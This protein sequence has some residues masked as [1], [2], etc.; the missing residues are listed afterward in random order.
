MAEDLVDVE[1]G[2]PSPA[3]VGA[4]EAWPGE[5]QTAGFG[6]FGSEKKALWQVWPS[7]NTF[8]F[9]GRLVQGGA[10]SCCASPGV[11]SCSG[12]NLCS[13]ALITV[14]TVLFFFMASQSMASDGPPAALV[15]VAAIAYTS[16]ATFLCLACCCDPGILPRRSVI[17]AAGCGPE[18]TR[19]LGYDPLGQGE[20]TNKRSIDEENMVPP[21][22]M[23]KGYRWCR[24]CQVVRPPR[25]SHCSE[26]DNC[27][28]RFDHHCPFV[29]NC[30][31]Q[32]NY[33]YFMGFTSSVCCLA[34]I[35]IP[36]LIWFSIGGSG[37][38]DGLED[39]V[40]LRY[41]L[42]AVAGAAAL[43]ALALATLWCYHLY[44][45]S[46]GKTT[47]E[48]LKGKRIADLDEEPT[49]CG[50]PGPQLFNQFAVVDVAKF[51]QLERPAGL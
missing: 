43:A 13:W 41:S 40:V 10:D 48:H 20:P 44:L 45:I 28:L 42:I 47:K 11:A 5:L 4:P 27:V 37:A 21:T 34:M 46:Q 22:L 24:T 16:T 39:S 49:L 23:R 3:T 33:R 7:N 15:F 6:E 25:A 38:F 14:P 30:V 8:W 26:C 12:E 17:L 50:A 1:T 9:S 35:V 36:S 19:A 18:L 29:N 51:R 2:M 32:R 31:G